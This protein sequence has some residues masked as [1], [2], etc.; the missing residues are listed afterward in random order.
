MVGNQVGVI[1]LFFIFMD[2]GLALNKLVVGN[3]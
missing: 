2:G 3:V 1:T